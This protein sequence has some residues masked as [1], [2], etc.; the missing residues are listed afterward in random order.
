MEIRR[1]N[2]NALDQEALAVPAL[3]SARQRRATGMEFH[4]LREWS[5][6]DLHLPHRT[7]SAGKKNTGALRIRKRSSARG[8]QTARVNVDR[9]FLARRIVRVCIAFEA[10]YRIFRIPASSFTLIVYILMARSMSLVQFR[11]FALPFGLAYL[12]IKSILFV[13]QPNESP[14]RCYLIL[15]FPRSPE[16]PLLLKQA[17]V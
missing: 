3:S 9:F 16:A 14:F 17:A 12:L 8:D 1:A 10:V 15:L 7:T 2:R 11:N 5:F 4:E 6:R 13:K